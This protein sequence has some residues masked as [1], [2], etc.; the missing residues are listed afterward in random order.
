MPFA[1]VCPFSALLFISILVFPVITSQ[2]SYLHLSPCFRVSFWESTLRW[3]DR[4][5]L[6]QR[7]NLPQRE[8]CLW[9]VISSVCQKSQHKN[10]STPLLY[11]SVLKSVHLLVKPE[12]LF[13]RRVK[14]SCKRLFS[15]TSGPQ[16][17]GAIIYSK[18]TLPPSL[19]QA[20]GCLFRN[21]F[22]RHVCSLPTALLP[23]VPH[24]DG[25]S[26]CTRALFCDSPSPTSFPSTKCTQPPK[27]TLTVLSC[28]K[29]A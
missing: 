24:G 28:M 23:S 25:E 21:S 18:Q 7:Y 4:K 6:E 29:Q 10:R 26:R 27:I 3:K 22:Y 19:S 12:A 2:V 14:D 11:A 15:S 9:A 8:E 20:S 5:Y 13:P 1:G 17:A 16:E